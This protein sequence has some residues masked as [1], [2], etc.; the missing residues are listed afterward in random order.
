[1]S[2]DVF[3]RFHHPQRKLLVGPGGIPLD[4]FLSTP[5]AQWFKDI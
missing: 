1:M 2:M 5:P 4:E 3:A